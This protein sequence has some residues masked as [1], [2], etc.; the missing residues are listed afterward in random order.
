MSK[1]YDIATPRKGKDDKTFW[2]R[3]GQPGRTTKASSSCSTPCP[4]PTR[5]ALLW[6]T[7]SE[8]RENRSGARGPQ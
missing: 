5:R 8:P 1:R 7:C 6:P 4:C 2:T 3:I